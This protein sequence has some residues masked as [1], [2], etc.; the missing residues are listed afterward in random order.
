MTEPEVLHVPSV[1]QAGAELFVSS[2]V[3]SIETRGQ[4]SVVLSGGTTPIA[5]FTLLKTQEL[6]WEKILLFW[7]DDRFVPPDHPDSNYRAAREALL[8]HVPV[9][10]HHIF[11]W[12]Y[13]EGDPEGA[14]TAY[15][16]TI[17]RALGSSFLFDLTYLGLGADAHTASLFPRT[18]AVHQPGITVVSN[19]VTAAHTRLSLTADALSQSRTVAFLVSGESKREALLNTLHGSQDSDRFPAQAIRARE[20][21]VWLTDIEL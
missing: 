21:L 4:F 8:A 15:A 2:A 19:P 3:Q 7:G 18:G 14:A 16:S 6:P 10:E 20:R 5:M 9:E 11:P 12:P 13:L 17:T 1:A